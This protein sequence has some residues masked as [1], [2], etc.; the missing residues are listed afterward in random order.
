MVLR[1]AVLPEWAKEDQNGPGV[2]NRNVVEPPTEKK[3]FGWAYLDYPP[4]NWLNWLARWT[5]RNLEYLIQQ[6][7]KE[8]IS[9]ADGA[10]LFP[11]PPTGTALCVL[12]A[13]D[14]AVPA[15]YIYAV[16]SNNNGNLTFNIIDSNVLTI[17]ANPIV[18][19]S[20]P[21]SGG[22]GPNNV[23]ACGQTKSQSVA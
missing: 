18:G 4:R 19:P 14:V 15:N 17:P 10:D 9:G 2:N 22:S 3:R 6:E 16:G 7:A 20:V 23:I 1:P 13:V 5:Y 11:I 12:Y 21:I 8:V